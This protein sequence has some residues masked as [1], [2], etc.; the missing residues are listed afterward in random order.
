MNLKKII[1]ADTR[2]K[3]AN[4]AGL[5]AQN[6]IAE[7]NE[8]MEVT[9]Y[10]FWENLG[11]DSEIFK[12]VLQ[13]VQSEISEKYVGGTSY[14]ASDVV[15]ESWMEWMQGKSFRID[16]EDE[17][18]APSSLAYYVAKCMRKR[19]NKKVRLRGLGR[20]SESHALGSHDARDKLE[21]IL[22]E[23]KNYFA[24]GENYRQTCYFPTRRAILEEFAENLCYIYEWERHK[25]QVMEYS[26]DLSEYEL[27]DRFFQPLGFHA[28]YELVKKQGLPFSEEDS[29]AMASQN[30]AGNALHLK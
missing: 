25:K 6:L 12:F 19:S 11:Q 4:I 13:E 23:M 17:L 7:L 28:V 2:I 14:D 24:V 5:R 15:Y 8:D 9:S 16:F 1:K 18:V 21:R 3:E 22:P 20:Y 10:S 29:D 26:F 27:S 30:S